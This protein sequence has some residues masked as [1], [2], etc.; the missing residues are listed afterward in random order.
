MPR[1]A[2]R[3]RKAWR[4]QV[5]RVVNWGSGPAATAEGPSG[6]PRSRRAAL[7]KASCVLLGVGLVLLCGYGLALVAALAHG[8]R[9][10]PDPD[11]PIKTSGT[12][13]GGPCPG[14]AIRW[15]TDRNLSLS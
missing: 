9:Y 1:R 13:W 10:R 4:G 12:G 5:W 7:M 3:E 11:A 8:P 6:V 15:G 14:G 2:A